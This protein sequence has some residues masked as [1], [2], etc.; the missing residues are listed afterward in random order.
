MM[1][2]ATSAVWSHSVLSYSCTE[3]GQQC[4]VVLSDRIITVA[5]S[6]SG[7]LGR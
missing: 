3:H 5:I 2:C 6:K 1:S 4:G 7:Q